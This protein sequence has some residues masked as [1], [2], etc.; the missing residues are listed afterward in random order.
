MIYNGYELFNVA[1]TIERADGFIVLR[2]YPESVVTRMSVPEFDERGNQIAEHI[3]HRTIARAS[4]GV[5][6]RFVSDSDRIGFTV[7][8]EQSASVAVY[9]GDW[10][11][12]FYTTE[13]G[14]RDLQ[15]ARH[16]NMHGVSAQACNR[17]SPKLW[18]IAITAGAP[19]AIKVDPVDRRAPTAADLPAVTALAYG[20][21]ITQGVGTPLV[22][23][24]YIDVAARI[25]GWQVKNKA[26]GGGCF[27]ETAVQDYLCGE[28]FDVG[29]FELA[30]NIANR[31][32]DVIDARVGRLIDT[33]CRTFP[34]KKLYFMTPVKGMSDVSAT[35]PDYRGYF[36]NAKRIITE[37]TRPFANAVLLDGHVLVGKDYYLSHDILHPSAFGHVMMGAQLAEMIASSF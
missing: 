1:E 2:R 35:A 3:G 12:A 5:E 14:K 20:T 29:Y 7:D 27:C 32:Y 15:A 16:G 11:V 25:L 24:G 19:V 30:T 17:F 4:V 34:D 18:R 26:I 31:P 10:Q 36:A 6:V 13:G 21:S 22:G 23:F 28:A 33:V 37:H 8:C 9:S